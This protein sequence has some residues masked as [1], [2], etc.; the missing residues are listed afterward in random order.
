MTNPTLSNLEAAT[1]YLLPNHQIILDEIRLKLRRQG[2]KASKSK[3][4][5][6]AIQLLE[7][8]P[9]EQLVHLLQLDA[10]E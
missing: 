9:L 5:R 6:V 7:T 4:A 8:Q 10:S 2:I 3:L 1:F